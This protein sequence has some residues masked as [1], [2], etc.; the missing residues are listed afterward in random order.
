MERAD[1]DSGFEPNMLYEQQFDFALSP[2][3]LFEVSH[4]CGPGEFECYYRADGCIS[5]DK[6]YDG[7][8]DCLRDGSDENNHSRTLKMNEMFP[9]GKAE[10]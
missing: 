5:W 7:V 1:W 8:I 4:C 3:L 6:V 9:N 10:N 2:V